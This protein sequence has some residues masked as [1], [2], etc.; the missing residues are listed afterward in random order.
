MTPSYRGHLAMLV[1]SALVAGSFSLGAMVANDIAPMALNAI[2][3]VIAAVVIGIAAQLTHGLHRKDFEAPWRFLVLGGLFA[4]YFVLMFYGL[5]TAAPVSAAA[6]F[7]LTPVLSGVFGWIL[8]RQITT[9]RMALALA[10]GAVGAIWVIFRGDLSAIWAFEIGRGEMI[11]FWG[12]VAHAAYTPMVR[13]LNRGEP[14]VVFTFGM[15]VA[16]A[17]ILLVVGWGD[18]RATDWTGLSPL[19]WVVLLYV[20]L[21]AS[22]ATF[23]LLQYATLHL[24]SA[25]VMAYTY[26]TPSWVI[27]WE[28]ALGRPAPSGIVALG[29]VCTIWALWLLLREGRSAVPNMQSG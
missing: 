20:A 19:V 2:R 15:L 10:I 14:A 18:I 22:A 17:I 11:Y 1:F 26:L 12:C 9:W 3:F 13:L 16:G 28:I 5:Q 4:I 25:K 24:P 7:T 8:L 23:V 6:V 27:L 29:V 21:I